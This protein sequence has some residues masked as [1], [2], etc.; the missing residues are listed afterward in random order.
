MSEPHACEAERLLADLVDA[1]AGICLDAEQ[2]GRWTP[3][4]QRVV[5]AALDH[6]AERR[7]GTGSGSV[8]AEHS[9]RNRRRG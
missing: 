8:D 5:I 9:A 1:L 3:S 7:D 6:V 2:L 4:V